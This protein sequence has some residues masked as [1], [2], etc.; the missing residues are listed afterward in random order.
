MENYERHN[1]IITEEALFE[2]ERI[3]K[4]ELKK[5]IDEG[6]NPLILDVRGIHALRESTIKIKGAVLA[7]PATVHRIIDK[8]PKDRQIITY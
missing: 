5:L 2:S 1:H 8:L 4:E 7:P 6:K 3:T